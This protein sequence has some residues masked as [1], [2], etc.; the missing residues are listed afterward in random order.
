FNS[1]WHD[2]ELRTG[3]A[4]SRSATY[5]MALKVELRVIKQ[6]RLHLFAHRGHVSLVEQELGRAAPAIA[7]LGVRQFQHVVCGLTNRAQD[8]TAPDRERLG[9]ILP[10]YVEGGICPR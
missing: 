1:L 7:A 10:E 5:S 3:G 4:Q 6:R 9:E 8:G 2:Q